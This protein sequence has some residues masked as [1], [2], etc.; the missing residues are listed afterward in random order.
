MLRKLTYPHCAGTACAL[1]IASWEGG[2]AEVVSGDHWRM[3]DKEASHEPG[4]CVAERTA[5]PCADL[6]TDL[7]MARCCN[8]CCKRCYLG[9]VILIATDLNESKYPNKVVGG[10]ACWS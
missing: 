8:R 5:L 1:A 6:G 9:P 4:W 10:V 2:R 7:K 3:S